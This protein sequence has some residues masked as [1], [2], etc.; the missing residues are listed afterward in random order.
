LRFCQKYGI[1]ERFHALIRNTVERYKRVAAKYKLSVTLLPLKRCG[2]TTEF[3]RRRISLLAP[4]STASTV[5]QAF[6]EIFIFAPHPYNALTIFQGLSI[7]H[8]I[9]LFQALELIATSS[10]NEKNPLF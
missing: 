8:R 3:L 1:S 2:I 6:I 7:S 4:M 9:I 10:S 5:L